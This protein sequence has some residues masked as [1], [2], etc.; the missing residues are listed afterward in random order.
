M[1]RGSDLAQL[2]SN[3]RLVAG[4]EGFDKAWAALIYVELETHLVR[5]FIFKS[6]RFHIKQTLGLLRGE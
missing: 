1:P 5:L 2:D 4:R 3:A 6:A